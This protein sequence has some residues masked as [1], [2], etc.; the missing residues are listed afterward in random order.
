M[1]THGLTEINSFC[2][3][4]QNQFQQP[5]NAT[6]ESPL[7]MQKVHIFLKAQVKLLYKEGNR[8]Q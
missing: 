1:K 2:A 4:F 3:N 7:R 8:T 5:K 6:S